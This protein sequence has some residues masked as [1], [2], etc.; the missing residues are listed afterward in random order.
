VP[1]LVIH[2]TE[3]PL[4][5]YAHAQAL[6]REIPGAQLLPMEQTGHGLPRVAW[7]QVVPAILSHTADEG[8]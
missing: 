5:P 4:F 8:R 3:D 6:A 2:G 1:T 7:D